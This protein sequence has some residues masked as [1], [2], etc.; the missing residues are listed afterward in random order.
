MLSF[1]YVVISELKGKHFETNQRVIS[2]LIQIYLL[3]ISFKPLSKLIITSRTPHCTVLVMFRH[4]H[5]LPSDL[6][7]KRQPLITVIVLKGS[8]VS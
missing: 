8:I 4:V 3:L 5:A 2:A 7:Y 6:V 1:D